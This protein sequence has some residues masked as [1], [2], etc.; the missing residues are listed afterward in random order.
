MLKTS[1]LALVATS[2]LASAVTPAAPH[3]ARPE[4]HQPAPRQAAARAGVRYLV[5]P[6][7]NEARYNVREQLLHHDLPNDAIGITTGITGAISVS[8][9]GAFDTANSRITIDV[10]TLKSDQERRDGYVQRRLLET[11]KYPKVTFVPTALV[12]AIAPLP[13]TGPQSFDLA[14]LITVHGVTKPT[15]WHVK[16]TSSGDDLTGSGYTKFTFADM[17][18]DQPHMPFILSLA[19]TIKL[20]YDFHLVRQH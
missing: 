7:G 1:L 12:G 8:S 19:D 4:T 13:T 18:L 14:G 15:V 6:T 17:S 11:D 20:E 16:A 10:T 2:A 5:A 3:A 9:T